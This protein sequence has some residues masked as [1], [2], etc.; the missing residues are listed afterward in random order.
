MSN[1]PKMMQH[2]LSG[3]LGDLK[4]VSELH[5][6]IERDVIDHAVDYLSEV[7]PS[8]TVFGVVSD[9]I[10][11][12]LLGEALSKK[13]ECKSIVLDKKVKPSLEIIKRVELE[14]ATW[15]VLIAVGSGTVNDICKY[16]SYRLNKP[17]VVLG[18][19]PSMNGYASANAS[20]IDNS[21]RISRNA[22]LP[23]AI[24]LD[25]EVLCA[26]PSRM[27]ASGIADVMC[28]M[29]CQADWFL[30][31]SLLN[32][33]YT[34]SPFKWLLPY[35]DILLQVG[36]DA[37]NRDVEVMQVLAQALIVSGL[38]MFACKGSY[39]ASQGEHMIAHA[40]EM[41]FPNQ[42]EDILHGELIAQTTK[43]MLDRQKRILN[44]S[45]KPYVLHHSDE[46]ITA[47]LKPLLPESHVTL[48]IKAYREKLASSEAADAL[49]HSLDSKWSVLRDR[50]QASLSQSARWEKLMDAISPAFSASEYL[51]SG[52]GYAT[53]ILVAT[54]LRNRFTFLDLDIE[55]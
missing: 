12:D 37:L 38:G 27:I 17:Y 2:L 21:Y 26:A 39:P 20:L 23:Q 29:T 31:H 28:R 13:I 24:F 42:V 52:Q 14:A 50:L 3:E 1:T 6:V 7:F 44:S 22:H 18:T 30:S 34:D 25:L 10:T 11:T 15:D 19:A 45:A 9:A 48:A 46:T 49:S 43:T 40:I 32:T 8:G 33:I 51:P 16:T 53:S 4:S 5:V 54:L 35:E 55:N 41:C 47:M 36:Q